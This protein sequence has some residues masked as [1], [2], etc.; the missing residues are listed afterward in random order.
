MRFSDL[1]HGDACFR[2]RTW[3]WILLILWCQGPAHLVQYKVVQG[4]AL[5]VSPDVWLSQ[6]LEYFFDASIVDFQKPCET[7][8]SGN[9]YEVLCFEE[10][11]HFDRHER[12]WRCAHAE[13]GGLKDQTT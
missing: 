11:L 4:T 5:T 8:N 10:N 13:A 1:R 2:T 7:R 6:R 9:A 3:D 12:F